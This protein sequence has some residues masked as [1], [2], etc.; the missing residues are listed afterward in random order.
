MSETENAA[1]SDAAED[2]TPKSA[3]QDNIERKGKNAY[4]FAHSHKAT[5]PQWDGKAEPRLL[6]R[7][8]SN[9][10]HMM[11]KLSLSFEYTKSNITT[12]AFMDEEKKV[13]LY[14]EM[15]GVGEKCTDEDINLD[16]TE[17]SLC[18]VVNNY[19]PEPQCLS[20]GRLTAP[21]THASFKRK[22]NRIILTLK[23]ATEGEWYTI[24]DKG[25]P[26][27]EVV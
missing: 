25:E 14:I 15:E 10:G 26:D 21:I 2:S 24:N 13:K 4:Y 23:K 1:A 5:G 17:T 3:L 11:S 22:D 9:D 19:K 16:Y 20:F 18:L 8:E 7:A 12:Y 27:N 6:S